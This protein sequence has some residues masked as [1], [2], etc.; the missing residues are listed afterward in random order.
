[1]NTGWAT[2]ISFVFLLSLPSSL[3]NITPGTDTC[4]QK[5]FVCSMSATKVVSKRIVKDLH[6]CI[7]GLQRYQPRNSYKCKTITGSLDSGGSNSISYS[8]FGFGLLPFN[9]LH[10]CWEKEEKKY[11]K[12]SLLT[13]G[14]TDLVWGDFLPLHFSWGV[15]QWFIRWAMQFP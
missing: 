2:E 3:T 1:M 5:W 8:Q 12:L 10:L 11:I 4:I 7:I 9:Y 15:L 14:N 13:Y 6:H